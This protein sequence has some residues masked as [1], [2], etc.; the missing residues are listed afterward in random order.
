MTSTPLDQSNYESTFKQPRLSVTSNLTGEC[1]SAEAPFG[2]EMEAIS[3]PQASSDSHSFDGDVPSTVPHD[4]S[5]FQVSQCFNSQCLKLNQGKPEVCQDCGKKLLLQNR[6]R[7]IKILARGGSAYIFVG[8][9]ELSQS[10]CSLKQYN[11]SNTSE[12][13]GEKEAAILKY[14]NNCSAIPHLLAFFQEEDQFYLITEFINGQS[15]FQIQQQQRCFNQAQVIDILNHLLPILE[16]I[17]QRQVIHRDIKPSNLIYQPDK[18]LALIDFGSSVF[19]KPEFQQTSLILGTPGYAPPEQLQGKVYPASDLYSLGATAWQ[20]LTGMMPPETG[21][22]LEWF[23]ETNDLALD[24]DFVNLIAKL[25]QPDW[26]LRY[27][28]ATEVLKNLSTIAQINPNKNYQQLEDYLAQQNYFLAEQITWE[29]I[30]HLAERETEGCLTL[31]AINN[32][33]ITELKT[34]DSL[35][36]KYSCDRFGFSV[37]KKIY[38]NL[39]DETKLDYLLWQQF[40]LQVGWYRE[41]QWLN[42]TQLDFTEAA[43]LGHLPVCCIDVFNR[44]GIDR[45]VCGW[46]RTGF[47]NLIEKI[48]F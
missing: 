31:E 48:D 38:Q 22:S 42:Y 10:V 18:S 26:K 19:F 11:Q 2:N 7:A 47:L 20:L 23:W 24:R 41:N 39:L 28:S 21:I 16:F 12:R 35:W 29:L 27:Q 3:S 14:L 40:A 33:S 6:Y 1:P 34:I 45:Y 32:L 25:L 37:Q 36:R 46:W 4:Y 15:L 13:L 43:P 30:L 17:H 44:V 5:S 9:D 8:L